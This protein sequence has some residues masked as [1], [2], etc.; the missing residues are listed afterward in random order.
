M[1]QRMMYF[2]PDPELLIPEFLLLS[3]YGPLTQTYVELATNG[4]TVGH[5]R[6]GQV[7]GLP[8]LWCPVDEQRTIVRYVREETEEIERTQANAEREVALLREYRT[9][10]IADVITGKLD[11]RDAAAQLPDSLEFELADDEALDAEGDD[12]ASLDEAIAED[13]AA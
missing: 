8:I 2:R 4:S 7:Y 11:V 5:L 6:L 12:D 1:G 13:E 10:L 9:R 3:I